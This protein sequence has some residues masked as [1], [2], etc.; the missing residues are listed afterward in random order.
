[1]RVALVLSKDRVALRPAT[2]ED[3]ET[4]YLWRNAESTR[5][6]FRDPRPVD[7]SVHIEWWGQMLKRPDRHLLVGV[8]Q[9]FQIGIVR[10]DLV[11]PDEAE[12]SLYLAPELT[13]LRLGSALLRAASAWVSTQLP[14]VSCVRADVD[15]GNE[16]SAR[17]F[18]A[19]GYSQCSDRSWLIKV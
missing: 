7:W 3:I 5:R 12:I 11:Q 8:V 18:E 9:S 1:M 19:A 15:P 6:V 4:A 10:L 16:N 17:A 13:G 2:Q 14:Q